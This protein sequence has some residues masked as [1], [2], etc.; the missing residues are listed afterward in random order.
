MF[1]T[2]LLLGAVSVEYRAVV[3]VLVAMQVCALATLLS[4]LLV[5][6]AAFSAQPAP[7]A[8]QQA[9][10]VSGK[11]GRHLRPLRADP[12]KLL[13]LG[14]L[15]KG[16]KLRGQVVGGIVQ[17]KTGPKVWLDVDVKRSGPGDK[18][19]PVRAMVRITTPQ[20]CMRVQSRTCIR[21]K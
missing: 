3:I 9:T 18:Y 21:N 20:V 14:T 13:D 10:F 2:A 1:G 17:G 16:T 5:D 6:V 4:V 8:A 19:A 12:A 11:P 7:A 15:T